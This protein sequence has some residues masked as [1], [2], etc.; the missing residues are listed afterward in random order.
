MRPRPG[1]LCMAIWLG[2][3]LPHVG[4][5]LLPPPLCSASC[6][7]VGV[8]DLAA[9]ACCACTAD[10]LPAGSTILVCPL[11][12][13]SQ[14]GGHPRPPEVDHDCRAPAGPHRQAVP[15]AVSLC[16]ALG[17]SWQ[18]LAALSRGAEK[19]RFLSC[20]AAR[21]PQPSK[22]PALRSKRDSS[23]RDGW[24]TI[25]LQPLRSLPTRSHTRGWPHHLQSS[26]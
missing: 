11:L 16:W 22:H 4:R 18:G 23:Q 20:Q 6:S 26:A 5:A 3:G 2:R 19:L 13:Y 1:L 12:S 25:G 9:A 17:R 15:G 24:P 10:I 7:S 14:A 21:P 8:W